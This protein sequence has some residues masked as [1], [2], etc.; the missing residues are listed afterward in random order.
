MFHFIFLLIQRIVFLVF[1]CCL[2]VKLYTM[3]NNLSIDFYK[4]F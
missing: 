1:P 3:Q 2:Q 4:I